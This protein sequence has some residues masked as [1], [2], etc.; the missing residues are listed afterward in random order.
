MKIVL[1]CLVSEKDKGQVKGT[2][3]QGQGQKR[4]KRD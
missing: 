3:V 1:F 2:W 4:N